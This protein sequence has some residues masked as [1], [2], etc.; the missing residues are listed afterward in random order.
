M[1]NI[2][3]ISTCLQLVYNYISIKNL[4]FEQE[5]F[6]KV[7]HNNIWTNLSNALTI[8]MCLYLLSKNSKWN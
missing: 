5:T 4:K 6:K 7:T 2:Y 8:F 3:D 1:P